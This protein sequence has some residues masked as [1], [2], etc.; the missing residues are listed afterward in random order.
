MSCEH[1]VLRAWLGG[2]QNDD[3]RFLVTRTE[4][5]ILDLSE[6]SLRACRVGR[7]PGRLSG[8]RMVV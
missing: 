7:V 5:L 3:A 8:D 6:S 4:R 1:L 2:H